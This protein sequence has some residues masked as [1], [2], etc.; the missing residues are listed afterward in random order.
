MLVQQNMVEY[1]ESSYSEGDKIYC[2]FVHGNALNNRLSGFKKQD[3]W[4]DNNTD[5]TNDYKYWVT[6]N[7]CL[8][9]FYVS[10][11]SRKDLQLLKEFKHGNAELRIYANF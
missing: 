5:S 10:I 8:Q 11:E 6:D 2:D 4:F 3:M 9:N 7:F 1:F